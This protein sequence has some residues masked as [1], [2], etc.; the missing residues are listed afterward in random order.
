M[1]QVLTRVSALVQGLFYLSPTRITEC[2]FYFYCYHLGNGLSNALCAAS[3]TFAKPLNANMRNTRCHKHDSGFLE[4][5][6][7]KCFLWLLLDIAACCSE[8]A[9]ICT[10]KFLL[11][12]V[13]P[14]ISK[15]K[16]SKV[17]PTFVNLRHTIWGDSRSWGNW[18]ST[19]TYIYACQ[20]W[21]RNPGDVLIHMQ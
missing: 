20:T 7:R 21:D 11:K 14:E 1:K 18:S 13:Q 4:T 9:Q 6:R 12:L 19:E 10:A 17:D 16:N 8:S 3:Q 5:I 15:P 2:C